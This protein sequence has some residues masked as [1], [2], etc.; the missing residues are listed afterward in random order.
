MKST[1]PENLNNEDLSKLRIRKIHTNSSKVSFG[2]A[3][4]C[5]CLSYK[6]MF[7]IKAPAA[8][9]PV[10][11]KRFVINGLKRLRLRR[12]IIHYLQYLRLRVYRI[13]PSNTLHL[14]L[15]VLK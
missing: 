9:V 3:I 6:T 12:R 14:F 8:I 13:F 7:L 1:F 15:A 5:I 10:T 2:N 4:L 11:T